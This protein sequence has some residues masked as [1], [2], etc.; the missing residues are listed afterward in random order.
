MALSQR[1]LKPPD[2]PDSRYRRNFTVKIVCS[3]RGQHPRGVLHHVLDT[4]GETDATERVI[5]P[6]G[7]KNGAPITSWNPEAPDESFRF[8]CPRCRRDVQL[9]QDSLF[10]IL[11]ALA[12]MD[13]ASSGH[14]VLDISLLP[15]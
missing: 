2:L 4:R 10:K 12:L 8:R 14:P 6:K 13:D 11:D 9:R 7:Q 5:W 3:D 15:C 1:K